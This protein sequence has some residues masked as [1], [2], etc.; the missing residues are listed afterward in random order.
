MG[1][2]RYF[3]RIPVLACPV[4]ARILSLYDGSQWDLEAMAELRERLLTA[5]GGD[6]KTHMATLAQVRH[7]TGAHWNR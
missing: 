3:V 5:E 1:I 6:I 4:V 7:W 2:W